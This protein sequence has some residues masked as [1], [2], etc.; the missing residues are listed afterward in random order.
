[1]SNIII[2][3]YQQEDNES[4]CSLLVEAFHG[5]FRSLVRLD[6][7]DIVE[8]VSKTWSTDSKNSSGQ[9]MVVKED[10]EII[11]TISLKW[12]DKNSIN[13]ADAKIN[14]KTRFKRFGFI[15]VCKFLIGMGFLEY[16]PKEDQECY[17]E[18]VAIH[19]RCRNKGI[20]QLFLTWA[21]DFI[22][23]HPEFEQLS[24]H[25][26]SKNKHAVHLYQKAGFGI[27]RSSYNLIRS[28]FFQEPNWH[29]M[30]W[31]VKEIRTND[32]GE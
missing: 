29:F 12:K 21:Q 14:Y 20:G 10:G 3:P 32:V 17:I 22:H 2:V 1:M 16:H 13:N 19:S 18:H 11:G 27:E 30:K 23:H 4:I 7:Q 15:N 6:D 28:L 9:Q 24:L 31:R 5:K 25:V 8:L 26:S